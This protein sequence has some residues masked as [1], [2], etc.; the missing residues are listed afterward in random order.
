[1]KI[2]LK[3]LILFSLINFSCENKL[4]SFENYLQKLS[5]NI[6]VN[7]LNRFINSEIDITGINIGNVYSEINKSM[8][9]L[10]RNDPVSIYLD[11]IS[12]N[13]YT[14][15]MFIT[16]SL[17]QYCKG[18]PLNIQK[19][20]KLFYEIENYKLKIKFNQSNKII[21]KKVLINDIKFKIG[22]TIV[23]SFLSDIDFGHKCLGFNKWMSDSLYY[24]SENMLDI[25][26]QVKK[27]YYKENELYFQCEILSLSDTNVFDNNIKLRKGINFDINLSLYG[28]ILKSFNDK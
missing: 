15:T 17:H 25:I 8:K 6:E 28:R 23:A 13:E 1:M 2:I 22:D 4:T 11:S 18:E 14:R 5:K 10:K 27:K 19:V 12:D 16:L 24:K 20:K 21:E 9:S 7:K 3:T 26:G